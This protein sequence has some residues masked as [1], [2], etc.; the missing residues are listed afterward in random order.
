M[1]L[2][3]EGIAYLPSLCASAL[4]A[5]STSKLLMKTMWMDPSYRPMMVVL[6]MPSAYAASGASPLSSI[7]QM[8]LFLGVI[9]EE[10]KSTVPGIISG[11]THY[12]SLNLVPVPL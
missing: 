5:K 3:S 11:M 9:P 6:G 2:K 8:G 4:D 10:G 1:P 12:L 7:P